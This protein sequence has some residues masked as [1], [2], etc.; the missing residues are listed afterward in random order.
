[1]VPSS[2]ANTLLSLFVSLI[3]KLDEHSLN[4]L[5]AHINK[6]VCFEIQ[7]II[8]LNLLITQE[9][10][11]LIDNP[12]H[13][14]ATFNGPL[15]AFMATLFSSKRTQSGLHIK[16]DL[17]C[18]KA[19]YDCTKQ[20]DID[21]EGHLAKGLGDN[22][23]HAVA[24]SFKETSQWAKNTFKARIDDLGIYLQDEKEL[25]PTR[26]EVEAFYKEVDLIRHDVERFAATINLLSEKK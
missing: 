12:E 19:F 2:V 17:E 21:W 24:T 22:M 14:D 10:L 9:G 7:D 15:N 18:A 11:T 23:A 1:M 4:P 8:T 13:V 6:V 20:L 25:L 16:G 5:K 3:K 26:E